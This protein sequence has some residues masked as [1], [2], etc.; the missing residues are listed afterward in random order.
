MRVFRVHP[1]DQK[2]RPDE[3]FGALYIPRG[4]GVGRWDNPDLYRLRYFSTTP[5]G[6]IA[7]TF[8]ALASWSNTMFHFPGPPS[9]PRALSSY[10]LSD[11]IRIADL[12]DIT[13]LT[14]LGINRFTDITQRNKRQTQRLAATIDESG[15]W[16]AISWWSY[17]H[18]TIT[19]VATWT[20]EHIELV[21]TTA[22]TIDNPAVIEA[23]NLIVRPFRDA[24]TGSAMNA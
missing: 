23:A 15:R 13:T 1:W 7:E 11:D 24:P 12:A 17:Y 18:P 6:A 10:E 4:Q 16:D 20:D 9:L 5:Q 8:G 2:A 14:T 19:L 22:L 3:P 21:D